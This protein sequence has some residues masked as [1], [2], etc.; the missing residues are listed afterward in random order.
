MK[1]INFKY[2]FLVIFISIFSINYSYAAKKS[3]FAELFVFAKDTNS[4]TIKERIKN[5][6]KISNKKPQP[7][8]FRSVTEYEFNEDFI[9]KYI[10]PKHFAELNESNFKTI[11]QIDLNDNGIFDTIVHFND[12]IT[13]YLDINENGIYEIEYVFNGSERYIYYDQNEDKKFDYAFVDY[14]GDGVDE[15]IIKIEN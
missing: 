14:N 8:K 9:S 15:E 1:R 3:I 10:I 4:G 6:T 11:E 2:F 13:A 5:I 7:R 12:P